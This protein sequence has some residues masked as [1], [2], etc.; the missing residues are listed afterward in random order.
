MGKSTLAANTVEG[1]SPGTCVRAILVPGGSASLPLKPGESPRE[2]QQRSK[3]NIGES[4]R[5]PGKPMGLGL[6][7]AWL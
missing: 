7:P 1:S 2:V 3:A 4:G 5:T 6:G